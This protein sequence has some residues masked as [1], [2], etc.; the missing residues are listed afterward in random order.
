MKT[1]LIFTS[2]V[3]LAVSAIA[4]DGVAEKKKAEAPAP[5]R[6]ALPR[7]GTVTVTTGSFF[8]Q[9]VRKSGLITDGALN[10]VVVDQDTIRTSGASTVPEILSRS[11]VHR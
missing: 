9:K 11:G 3:L 5:K 4:S 6:H 8:Q 7:T 10:I 1:P 2:V